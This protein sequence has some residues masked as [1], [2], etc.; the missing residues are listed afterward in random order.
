MI[1]FAFLK[2]LLQKFRDNV[3]FYGILVTFIKLV[4]TMLGMWGCSFWGQ[5]ILGRYKVLTDTNLISTA[6]LSF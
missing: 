3:V 1:Q 4:Q 2:S 5:I 6:F